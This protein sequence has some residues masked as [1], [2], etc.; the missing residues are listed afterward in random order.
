MTVIK[1][2][3]RNGRIE[4][5]DPINLPDGTELAIPI[6]DHAPTIGIREEDWSDSPEAIEAWI[7]WF[8][9]LEP[10]EWTNEERAAWQS[11]RQEQRDY[12]LAEW[13]KRSG[14]MEGHFS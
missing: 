1:A 5:D 6:P 3:V 11:A 7:R 9:A 4:V 8:D 12:E 13:D 2:I 14:H 10:L